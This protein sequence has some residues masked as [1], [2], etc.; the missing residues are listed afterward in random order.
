MPDE[1]TLYYPDKNLIKGAERWMNRG[2][3]IIQYQESLEIFDHLNSGLLRKVFTP[4]EVLRLEK[5]EK[6]Y[7]LK[8]KTNWQSIRLDKIAK[9]AVKILREKGFI[10]IKIK[11]TSDRNIYPRIWQRSIT[12]E[13]VLA[14]EITRRKLIF[15]YER[16]NE[17]AGRIKEIHQILGPFLE[18]MGV[19]DARP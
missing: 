15:K 1:V 3:R 18:S 8:I 9:D 17:V 5:I 7:G 16:Y 13:N 2:F 11:V 14:M 12:A 10:G 4:D 19:R 6:E